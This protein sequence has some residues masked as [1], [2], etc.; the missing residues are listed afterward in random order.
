MPTTT[1]KPRPPL[2]EGPYLVVGLA[3]SGQ[4]AAR[5]LAERGAEVLGV[6]AGSP[7]GAEGLRAVGVE[8]SLDGQG[9]DLLERAR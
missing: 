8:V 1:P 6:D 5:L 2:P 7:E 3:R 4:A 9:V